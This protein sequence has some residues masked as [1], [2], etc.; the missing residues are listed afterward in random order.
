MP[1]LLMRRPRTRSPR[2]PRQ[3]WRC[4]PQRY[5]A[6]LEPRSAGRAR[7]HA[8]VTYTPR[9][10]SKSPH[11]PTY[12]EASASLASAALT[13]TPGCL[14]DSGRARGGT[15]I[16]W[17]IWRAGCRHR[18]SRCG[19]VLDD[20]APCPAVISHTSRFS[21]TPRRKFSTQAAWSRLRPDPQQTPFSD[22][23]EC[24]T[25]WS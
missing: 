20:L 10:L 4:P 16:S 18:K 7:A 9:V 5:N 17:D 11:I 12:A 1:S 23:S 2:P 15:Q 19:G 24:F 6:A 3:L 22:R 8:C 13:V 14:D 21:K 25:C